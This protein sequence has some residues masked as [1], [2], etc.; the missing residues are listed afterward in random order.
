M[1][2]LC[3]HNVWRLSTLW[4]CLQLVKVRLILYEEQSIYFA[5]QGLAEP[6]F[7]SNSA[8][9]NHRANY[10]NCLDKLFYL[11]LKIEHNHNRSVT[12]YVVFGISEGVLILRSAR[13]RASL[14]MVY[15]SLQN[16]FTSDHFHIFRKQ[17]PLLKSWSKFFD[18][19]ICADDAKDI[20]ETAHW[21]LFNKR[22]TRFRDFK[23]I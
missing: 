19:R 12:R 5:A 9:D 13:Q 20:Q 4:I 3:I 10:E 16:T 23:S 21:K 1:G 8:S 22:A 6:H 14:A 11:Y 7:H 2:L 18:K 17:G 15:R